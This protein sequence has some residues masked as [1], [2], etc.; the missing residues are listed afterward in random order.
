MATLVLDLQ[1]DSLDKTVSTTDLLRKALMVARKLRVTNLVEWLTHELNGYPD[2]TEIPAYRKLKG[3]LKVYNPY[4]GWIPLTIANAAHAELLSERGT[5]QAISELDRIS[6]G[7]SD[8]VYI[9]LPPSVGRSLM[10]GMEFPMEPALFLSKTQIHGL[11]DKVRNA[12]LEWA[13]SLEE[14]GIMGEGMSFS[15]EE[16][17]QAGS[18]TLNVQH[19]GNLIGSMHD[20]QV[21]QDTT[22]ST[23]TYS[24]P[25][26]LEAIAKI[27][28]ELQSR[29]AKERLKPEEEAQVKS[30]IACVETQLA[31]PRPNVR[32]IKES[33]RS[34]RAILEGV[35]G[36]AVFQGIL[37][38][39]GILLR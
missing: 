4:H 25:L 23:Q 14:Q 36:N 15:Q 1:K 33:L 13:L 7:D 10:K 3:E 22:N 34:T 5:S 39:L 8:A 17:R 6:N 12:V 29:M 28:E 2:G 16:Q 11:V 35:A 27:I 19:L 38:A 32:V 30:E 31:A 21:Q 24:K 18:V 20:S 9:R 37:T 26:D